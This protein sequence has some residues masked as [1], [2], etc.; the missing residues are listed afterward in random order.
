LLLALLVAL[1]GCYES[2]SDRRQE[3]QTRPSAALLPRPGGPIL[4]EAAIIP[5]SDEELLDK[6]LRQVLEK[7]RTAFVLV[8]VSS[9]G[10]TEVG[11]YTNALARSWDVGAARGG[12]VLLVAPND[13]SLRIE[14]S[15]EVRTRLTDQE[16][17]RIIEQ[18]IVPRFERGDLLAGITLGVEAIA[19]QIEPPT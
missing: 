3:K 17:A 14:T 7:T 5:P 8:T 4:D 16:S 6:R 13:R 19:A 2:A 15:D 10:G 1:P 9:L 11:A 12:V 18:V